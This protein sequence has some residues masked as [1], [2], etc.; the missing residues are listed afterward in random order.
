MPQA[1]AKLRP[2]NKEILE[3]GFSA[4]SE[5]YKELSAA[6]ADFKTVYDSMAAYRAKAYVWF[7][8]AE[9]QFDTFMMLMQRAHML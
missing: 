7:Q 6:N 9:Y 5:V 3:S 8:I 4:A 2:F 1:G